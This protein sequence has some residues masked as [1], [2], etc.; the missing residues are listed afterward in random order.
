MIKKTLLLQ[1][2]TIKQVQAKFIFGQDHNTLGILVIFNLILEVP[3]D[4]GYQ[5]A[6]HVN[7]DFTPIIAFLLF[8]MEVTQLLVV[9]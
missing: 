3:V 6:L 8:F 9:D 1:A 7:K 2:V 4:L 5:K